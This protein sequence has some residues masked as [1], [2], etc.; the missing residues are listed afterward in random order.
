MTPGA[1]LPRRALSRSANPV[2]LGGAG[3]ALLLLVVGGLWAAGVIFRVET[4]QGSLVVKVAD[5]D[6]TT[7]VQGTTVTIKNATS[8][9]TY[10]ITLDDPNTKKKFA[11]GDYEF[12]LDTAAGL[13]TRTKR[14]QISRGQ[15]AVVE[16][17]WEPDVKADPTAPSKE[18]DI[19]ADPTAP[20]KEP[21]AHAG[22][23]KP[24]AGPPEATTA[25]EPIP[26]APVVIAEPSATAQASEPP[27]PNWTDWPADGPPPAIV[28]FNADTAKQHQQAWA[29]YL[30]LPV[31]RELELADDIQLKL[32]FIPPGEFQMERPATEEDGK[33]EEEQVSVT[34][35]QGFYLGETEVT[36]AQWIEVMGTM[37]WSGGTTLIKEGP[38]HAATYIGWNDA[39]EF[40]KTL[41]EQEQAAGRLAKDWR[42][43]LPT[44]AQWVYACRAGKTTAYSFGD[45]QTL[46]GDYAWFKDNA[47]DRDEKYAH[48]VRQKKPND[49]GLYD[50][51]GNVSEW[52]RDGVGNGH[53]A[54]VDPFVF[55]G[56]LRV[57]RGGSWINDAGGCELPS[58]SASN[59]SL[60]SHD[61]GFRLAAVPVGGAVSG[62][63]TDTPRPNWHGWPA[64]GP[65]PAIV[66]FNADTAKQHQQ[67]WA[68][69]LKL[70]VERELELADDVQLKLVFIPPGEFPAGS[71]A[72]ENGKTEE[73]EVSVTLTQGF[74]LGETEVT[75]AQW[76][77]VMGTVPWSGGQTLVK[78]GP[79]HAA[80]YISWEDAAEFCKALTEQEQAAGRLAKDWRY[81]LPTDAQWVY[82]CRAGKT[83]AYSFGDDQ[84]LL[85][86]YAWFKDNAE[87]QDEKYAHEVRQKKPND[88][89]LYDIHGNAWEW[90]RDGVGNRHPAGVDPFVLGRLL[91]V[92]RGGSWLNAAGGCELSSRGA[93]NLSLRSHYL[94]FRLAAVP[95]AESGQYR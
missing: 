29:T 52:A 35:T 37:P 2:L 86:D 68:T 18:P 12:V 72:E 33:T 73:D 8:N 74:Y 84:T 21:D 56:L 71:L 69:Y 48:E 39:A 17:W 7:L 20:S 28:P 92:Y 23:K 81:D 91:R 53:P 49:W 43:D 87:A 38:A 85:G 6:F 3:L 40:C 95:V 9:E 11:P 24:S 63:E 10:K 77:E 80:T 50:I 66:P 61:L 57:H 22:N 60:R 19:K 30:N 27:T 89:G 45:D 47:E 76:I 82:A 79:A 4:E 64:D 59:L 14:F 62:A 41:T 31:E 88:W 90:A 94:G 44:D 54:E 78:E 51:H 16:V 46:L 15:D 65:P 1:S 58:R 75:Q 26:P 5:D 55:G 32:V 93:S 42:Y 70:P 34:L 13:R 67:A 83:T 36:Q 25:V